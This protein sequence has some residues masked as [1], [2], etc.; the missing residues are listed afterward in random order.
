[1]R[2]NYIKVISDDYDD[3]QWQWLVE[4]FNGNE[5]VWADYYRTKP[6][7]QTIFNSMEGAIYA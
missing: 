4:V 5:L 6:S 2:I 1:M 3:R 7:A